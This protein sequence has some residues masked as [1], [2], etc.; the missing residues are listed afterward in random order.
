MVP[1]THS[2]IA[3]SATTKQSSFR[4]AKLDCFEEPVIGRRFAPT[5][6]LVMTIRLLPPNAS[7]ASHL[8]FD[9][10]R[11]LF[12]DAF[13]QRLDEVVDVADRAARNTHALG[14]RNKVYGRAVELQHVHRAL[15]RFA[16][17]NAIEFAAQDLVD[18]VGKHDG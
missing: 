12:G 8:H 6:W 14:K 9:Q 13:G 17:A 15:S 5:R 16:C 10:P 18:A 3:R 4:C 7:F 1:P 2:V 11:T